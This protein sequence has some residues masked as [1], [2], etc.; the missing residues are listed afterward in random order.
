MKILRYRR[1][2]LLRDKQTAGQRTGRVLCLALM[3][4][5]GYTMMI[6]ASPDCSVVYR[7]YWWTYQNVSPWLAMKM[8]PAIEVCDGV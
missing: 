6:W 2:F 8:M 4:W 1:S 3:M 7:A 5:L